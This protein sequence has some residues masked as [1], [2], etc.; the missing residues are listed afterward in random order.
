MTS[1]VGVLRAADGMAEA[2]TRLAELAAVEGSVG[3]DD[4]ETSNVLTISTAL[5]AAATLRE[6]T[7][8]S[9]WREDFPDRDDARWAGHVDIRLGPDGLGLAFTFAPASDGAPVAGGVA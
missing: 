7:R 1:K 4:W 5:C 8:G 9:H 2:A 3:T 6:E